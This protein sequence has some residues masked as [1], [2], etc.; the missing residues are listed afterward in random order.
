MYMKSE[1]R[2]ES[3]IGDSP[4][5]IE[6]CMNCPL[7]DCIDCMDSARTSFK[8]VSGS[9]DEIKELKQKKKKMTKVELSILQAYPYAQTDNDL[10]KAVGV[11]A[12]TACTA[13]KKLGLPI[14]KWT[15]QDMRKKLVDL[16][17]KN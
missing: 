11:A 6:M 17:L 10:A 9:F 12:S 4:E 16:W 3:C 15:T 7:E 1:G 8:D 5:Q 14:I 13:R 2:F